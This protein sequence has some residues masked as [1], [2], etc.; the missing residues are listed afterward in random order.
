M[1]HVTSAV[2]SVPSPLHSPGSQSGK[3]VEVDVDDVVVVDVEVDDVDEDEVVELDVE[4]VVEVDVEVVDVVDVD[5]V[6][7]EEVDVVVTD[8]DVVLEVDVEV[9]VEVEVVVLVVVAMHGALPKPQIR[10]IE[11]S[12]LP[13]KVPTNRSSVM[14]S[15]SRPTGPPMP[16]TS[17]SSDAKRSSTGFVL[18]KNGPRSWSTG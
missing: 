12:G 4:D 9:D 2:V 15:N 8:V 7:V 11:S 5:V 10:R 14:G 18:P 3:V 16:S 13:T 17:S 1:T 6:V